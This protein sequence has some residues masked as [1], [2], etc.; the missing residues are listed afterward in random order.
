MNS[1]RNIHELE[2]EK[3]PKGHVTLVGVG[4]LGLRIG[5]NLI[6]AHRGG[7]KEISAIDG[8][9]I[10]GSD[11][12]FRLLGGKSGDYKAEFLKDLCTHPEN[13]RL[14]NAI[15]ENISEKNLDLIKG[16][17]VSIQIAGGN[18]IP[19]TAAIIKCAHEIGA[20]TIST[21]GVFGIGE[22]KIEILDISDVNNSNPISRE[23]K[24][25]GIEENHK[26]VTTGRFIEDNL[27]V[28]PYVLDTFSSEMTREIFKMLI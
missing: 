3:I 23:L 20:K 24:A 6:Q 15:N 28:T 1:Y 2:N 17:V 8:Q 13:L 27:P 18:T 7:P 4:R 14:V 9:Q 21:A 25:H 12:I 5:V 10:S 11:I 22:E 26:M 19:L 16:D